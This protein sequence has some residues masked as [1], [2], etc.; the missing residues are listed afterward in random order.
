MMDRA[1][2]WCGYMAALA[3]V[4]IFTVTMV[5]ILGRAVGINIRGLTDYVGYFMAGSA[6]LA[7]PH[8]LNRGSHVKISLFLQMAGP[9]RG[10][11]E[12]LAYALTSAIAIWLAYY[13]CSLVYWSYKLGDISQGQDA[14]PMWIPQVPMAVGMVMLAVAVVDH[15]FRLIISGHDGIDVAPDTL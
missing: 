14:T 6:F 10:G 13:S 12:K 4:L 1:Y 7:L 2:L 5:Q 8:A 9:L 15:G 11:L 3:M